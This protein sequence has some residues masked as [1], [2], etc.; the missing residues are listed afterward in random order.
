MK[1]P[2]NQFAIIIGIVFIIQGVWELFSPVVAVVLT[3]N[4]LHGSSILR[5]GSSE[6]YSA[7]SDARPAFVCSSGYFS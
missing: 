7:L 4:V 2:A 1:S 3:G 5:S 6:L